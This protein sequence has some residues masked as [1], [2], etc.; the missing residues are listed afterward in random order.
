MR[1][2]VSSFFGYYGISPRNHSDEILFVETGS[3]EERNYSL[4]NL[5]IYKYNQANSSRSLYLRYV[6]LELATRMYLQW[7]GDSNSKV[8]FN[9]YDNDSDEYCAKEMDL[10]TGK[11]RLF[12]KAIYSISRNGKFALSLN[13]ERLAQ[14]RPDYG[15][16]VKKSLPF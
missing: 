13:F 4:T 12:S 1:R 6:C 3:K 2:S 5:S 7:K 16:F 11:T 10:L 15:Y 9:V 14:M 8:I